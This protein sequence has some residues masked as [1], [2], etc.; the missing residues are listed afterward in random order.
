MRFLFLLLGLSNCYLANGQNRIT[1]KK[2][3]DGKLTFACSVNNKDTPCTVIDTRQDIPMAFDVALPK[4]QT[5]VVTDTK[6]QKTPSHANNSDIIG[7]SDDLTAAYNI[8]I[9][10]SPNEILTIPNVGSDKTAPV[11]PGPGKPVVVDKNCTCHGQ[12]KEIAKRSGDIV[13]A[14]DLCPDCG[15]ENFIVYD[16]HCKSLYKRNEDNTFSRITNLGDVSFKYKKEFKVKI[17]HVNRYLK[18]VLITADDLIYKSEAPSLFDDFFGSSGQLLTGLRGAVRAQGSG[19]KTA[20]NKFE[21]ALGEFTTLINEL[22]EKR[23]RAYSLCCEATE[24]CGQINLG[25]SFSDLSSRLFNLNVNYNSL[26]TELKKEATE[27]DALKASLKK[28]EEEIAKAKEA[29]KPALNTKKD[30]IETKIKDF[31]DNLD[32]QIKQLDAIWAVFEKPTEEQI[33]NLILFSK[34]YLKENY[35]FSTPPIYPLGNRLNIKINIDSKDD[36]KEIK[37]RIIPTDH[38]ALEIEGPVLNKWLFSFSSGPFIGFHNALYE[39]N[40]QF[41]KIPSSGN[42]IDENSR[43]TLTPSGKTNPP[44]GLSALAHFEN[45]FAENFGWGLSVGVGLTIETKTRPVY[46][47]GPSF[48]I[49]DKNRFAITVGVAAMQVDVLKKN[50]YPDGLVYK[51]VET[52]QYYKDLRMGGF[53]SLTYTLFTVESKNKQP[54]ITTSTSTTTPNKP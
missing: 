37:E 45:K 9:T 24:N 5:I 1:I 46:L 25:T 14:L 23:D 7:A 39:T 19:T 42:L 31:A 6:G 50:L 3:V 49:G 22:K 53:F 54:K 52:L 40:Y 13:N 16:A 21:V 20:Y 11:I 34:N 43:Y 29:D 33:R 30:D 10:F 36:I 44:V 51:N 18:D 17:I 12:T 32:D 41:Q 15:D 28:V 8:T 4:P 47:F 2:D 27:R 26:A 48:F 38:Q 35:T